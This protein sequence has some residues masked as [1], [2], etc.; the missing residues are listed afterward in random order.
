LIQD[1]LSGKVYRFKPM[2]SICASCGKGNIVGRRVT[3]SGKRNRR[4]FKVNLHTFWVM[5]G[6]EH[7]KKQFCTKCL[8]RVRTL[9]KN[10]AADAVKGKEI[11]HQNVTPG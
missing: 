6:T 2:A 1:V 3:F 7:V 4:V 9:G 5:E 8:R 11:R 10:L